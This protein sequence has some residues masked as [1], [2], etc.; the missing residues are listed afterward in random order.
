MRVFFASKTNDGYTE[1][2]SCLKFYL[3]RGSAAAGRAHRRVLPSEGRKRERGVV[4]VAERR[5][6]YES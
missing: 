6:N 2:D 1:T 3:P 4:R 5:A